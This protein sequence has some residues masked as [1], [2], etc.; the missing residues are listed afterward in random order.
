MEVNFY[1]RTQAEFDA[2]PPE[3]K[4]DQALYFISDTG[5]IKQYDLA[6]DS[7]IPY[8]GQPTDQFLDGGGVDEIYQIDDVIDEGEIV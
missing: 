1:K 8:G 4:E 7:F 2:L 5:V 3:E 6:T